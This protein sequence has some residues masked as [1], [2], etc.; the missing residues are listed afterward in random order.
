M[1]DTPQQATSN[2]QFI[3]LIDIVE[4]V[5][6]KNRTIQFGCPGATEWVWTKL[7]APFLHGLCCLSGGD[8]FHFPCL[9]AF[10]LESFQPLQAHQLTALPQHIT[11]VFAQA[12]CI[13]AT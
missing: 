8:T 6:R 3:M 1:E 4:S 12:G 10:P 9:F 13:D 2:R 11:L 5:E 7:L